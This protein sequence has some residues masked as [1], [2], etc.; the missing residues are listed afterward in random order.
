VGSKHGAA[1]D[2]GVLRFIADPKFIRWHRR[3]V[4]E[5]TS[6]HGNE[7]VA[8]SVPEPSRCGTTWLDYAI[9][10]AAILVIAFF[11]GSIF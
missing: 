3:L 4:S 9:L 7:R 2:A 10:V 11:L 6:V 5:F 8:R 1:R